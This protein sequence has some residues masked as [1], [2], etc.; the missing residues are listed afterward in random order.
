[1]ADLYANIS[2]GHENDWNVL[3]KRIIAAAQ[4]HSDAIVIS[5]ATP[6]FTIPKNKKYVSIKSKWGNLHYLEGCPLKFML[7]CVGAPPTDG[8]LTSIYFSN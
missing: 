1:M 3:E 8:F 2:I 6:E 4:C 5:K 7:I